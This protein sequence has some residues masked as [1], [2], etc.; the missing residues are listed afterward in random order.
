MGILATQFSKYELA[1]EFF[2]KALKANPEHIQYQQS[3][4]NA[5][6]KIATSTVIEDIDKKLISLYSQ[7]QYSEALNLAKK[8]IE[9]NPNYIFGWKIIGT[10]LYMFKDYNNAILHL[11]KA[12]LLDTNDPEIHNNLGIS[13]EKLG[14]FEEAE[15]SYR[16]AIFINNNYIDA[17]GNLGVVLYNLGKLE[18]AEKNYR[19]VIQIKPD[20]A[21]AYNNLGIV[22]R[23]LGRLQEAEKSYQKAIEIEPDYAEAYNNLGVVFRDLG[24]FN[25][26]EK[27]YRKAIEIKHDYSEAYYNI[28]NILKYIRYLESNA[29]I[30]NI[31]LRILED[32]IV[33]PKDVS[34]A[35]ISLIK[36]NS[37]YNLVVNNEHYGEYIF[38]PY[39]IS[40]LQ[41]IPLLL[42]LMS[43]VPIPDLEIEHLLTT[44]RKLCLLN[45]DIFVNEKDFDS[46]HFLSSLALQCFTNEYVYMVTN[47]EY[48]AL[49]KLKQSITDTFAKGMTPNIKSIVVLASYEPLYSF[50]WIDKI[51]FPSELSEIQVRQVK[52]PKYEKVLRKKILSLQN[53]T[54]NVSSKVKEQYE[55]NP[56]P[57]WIYTGISHSP[58]KIVHL[59]KELDI[60]VD[61]KPL[62]KIDTPEILIA[63][64]G[65][66][67]HSIGT[68]SRFRNSKVLAIDL[69]FSSLAYAKRKTE[70]LNINNI[71]YMQADILN[72]GKLGKTFDIIESVGV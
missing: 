14:K 42:K 32:K 67:Q 22:L 43:L 63:G 5:K 23:D 69:S 68:A 48:I 19:N 56:Y 54:D 12:L 60:N 38:V 35:A 29:K 49:E 50:P 41:K 45:I 61:L 40:K 30:E 66:G 20:Y 4:D 46:E 27:S 13:L 7:Q 39:A 70:E 62:K 36:L 6:V 47:E 21:K 59:T 65:T 31:I 1:I 16:E 37:N 11:Q 3:L 44:I 9:K 2:E 25:E 57:R 15:K 10:L 58:Y 18:E 26:A 72:I 17:Y 71:E 28:G 64:C 51:I 53:I 33:R 8:A 52:E 34:K 55:S 24:R